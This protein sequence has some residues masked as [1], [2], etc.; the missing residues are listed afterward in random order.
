MQLQT[1]YFRNLII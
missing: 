1:L